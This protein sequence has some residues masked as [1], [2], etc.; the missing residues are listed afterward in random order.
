MNVLTGPILPVQKTLP[1]DRSEVAYTLWE[2]ADR[3]NPVVLPWRTAE[4]F[5][6]SEVRTL[7]S[8][9]RT[10]VA[11]GLRPEIL[12]QVVAGLKPGARAY[13]YGPASAESNSALTQALNKTSDRLAIRL[14]HEV[15]VDWI[16]VDG[17]RAGVALIGPPSDP[18][19]WALPLEAALARSLFEV[20]RVLWWHHARREGLPDSA[21]KFAFR[22]PLPSPFADPGRSLALPAGRFAFDQ[23]LPD[24]VP[25][26]EFRVVPDGGSPGRGGVILMPPSSASFDI[27]RRVAISGARVVW[28]DCGLPRTTVSRQRL[29][30]DLVRGPL[31]IQLEWETGTAVDVYHRLGKACEAP[32]W[33]FHLQR[34]LRDINGAVWLEGTSAAAPVRNEQ[35]IELG[36]LRASLS[37]F[38]AAA[39][40]QLPEP[41]PLA[42]Q[43]VYEWLTVPETV[44]TGAA[45]AQ[46]VRQ[47]IALDEWASR[48]VSVLQQSLASMEGEERSFL[49]RLKGWLRGQDAVQRERDRLRDALVEIGEQTPSQR[50]D[51]RETVSRLVEES[52]RLQGLIQQAHRDRQDAEDRADEAVQRRAWE[53]RVTAATHEL[54]ALR[55]ELGALDVQDSAADADLRAAETALTNRTAELRS[56]RSAALAEARDRDDRLLVEARAQLKELDAKHRGKAPKDERKAL[57]VEIGR[58]EERVTAA[59]RDIAAMDRWVPAPADLADENTALRKGREAKE[60]VRKRRAPLTAEIPKLERAAHEEFQN[61][62]SIR[63]AAAILPDL[64]S[65]PPVP[66]EAPPE[67]GELFEHHGQ[68]FLA[69]RTWEQAQRATRVATRLRGSMVA[70][71]PSSK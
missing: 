30:M 49:G 3:P 37:E 2:R 53:A 43:V 10:V 21:G 38:E 23:P 50:R 12:E 64:G 45:K 5:N 39:P 31:G 61:R 19:R 11:A 41:A 69:V 56:S 16:V 51:A 27:A 33:S 24:P 25:D 8:S 46:I 32:A 44:P 15:P 52:G 28:S 48:G 26:A 65:A 1:L 58:L 66:N 71:S 6:E 62:P 57:T 14:G 4:S 55:G 29:V 7:V 42:R 47:W 68:R 35:R 22:P 17:G 9:A 20:F 40:L 34:R 18:R 59:K 70:F 36:E 13:W 54:N 63:L 60:G 67:I